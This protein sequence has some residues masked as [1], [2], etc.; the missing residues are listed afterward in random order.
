MKVIDLTEDKKDLFC[1]C[2]EDWSEEA[3]E[4]GPSAG[5]GWTGAR[6]WGCGPSSPW[7]TTGSKA[8]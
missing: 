3:K 6:S 5:N 4:A 7:T 8:G 1:L 2:L